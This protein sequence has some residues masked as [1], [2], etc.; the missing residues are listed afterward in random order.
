MEHGLKK[1]KIFFYVRALAL[2]TPLGMRIIKKC[3]AALL[4]PWTKVPVACKNKEFYMILNTSK[5]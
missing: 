1:S 4:S 5:Y 3:G 2:P